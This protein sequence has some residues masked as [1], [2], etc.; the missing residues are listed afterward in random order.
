[1][2]TALTALAAGG[3]AAAAIRWT[4]SGPA[5]RGLWWVGG[6][7]AAVAAWAVVASGAPVP[8]GSALAGAG[9]AAAAVVDAVEGRIPTPVAYA[10]AVTAALSIV[11]A[12]LSGDV[13]AA[14]RAAALTGVFVLGCAALWLAGAIGFGDVRLAAGTATA[15]LGGAPALVLVVWASAAGVGSLALFGR[16]RWGGRPDRG[17]VVDR[18]SV[19]CA[20]AFALAW[21][22]AVVVI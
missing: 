15:M 3:V 16:S 18:P 17:E 10:T 13:G 9:L 20:P 4:A 12:G 7:V 14:V 11:V 1:V 21:L 5:A 8:V 22:L 2:L 6:T 19:P